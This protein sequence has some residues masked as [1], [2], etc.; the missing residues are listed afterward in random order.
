MIAVVDADGS[1]ARILGD[2]AMPSFSPAGH[3]IAFSRYKERGV[4]VMSSEGPEELLSLIDDKG[5]GADWSPDGTRIA[6]TTYEDGGNIVVYSLVEGTYQRLF[7]DDENPYRHFYWNFAWSGDS[8]QI[9]F[10]GTRKNGGTEVA[11]VDARGAKHGLKTVYDGE[12]LPALAWSPDSKTILVT[13]RNPD[14]GKRW[15]LHAIDAVNPGEPKRLS[16]QV[17]GGQFTDMAYSPDGQQI[18]VT[19][20]LPKGKK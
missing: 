7:S 4:W 8:Q 12:T 9:V 3:R 20:V 19:T 10:R 14:E 2:G 18:A 5:W 15:Q 1:N 6:Y 17:K 16:G 13:I 11:V